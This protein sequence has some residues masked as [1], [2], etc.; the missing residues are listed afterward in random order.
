[1]WKITGIDVFEQ[2]YYNY[3]RDG[4]E[5]SSDGEK[6]SSRISTRTTRDGYDG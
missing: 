1:M 5:Q 2:M 3:N 4:K 6:G